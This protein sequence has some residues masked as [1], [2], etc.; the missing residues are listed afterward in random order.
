[1]RKILKYLL[2]IFLC[3]N[4]IILSSCDKMEP[5]LTIEQTNQKV[6]SLELYFRYTNDKRIHTSSTFL[7]KQEGEVLNL[8][9]YRL[10]VDGFVFEGW[11]KDSKYT[12]PII[13][14][15]QFVVMKN[16]KIYGH[17]VAQE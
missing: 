1:M 5:E 6:Y 12:K 4:V 16:Q 10:Q 7:S 14:E 15:N 8:E 17:L 3:F 13:D 11:Y 9:P 2:M